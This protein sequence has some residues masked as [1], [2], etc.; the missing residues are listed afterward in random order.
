M[1]EKSLEQIAFEMGT[2]MLNDTVSFDKKLQDIIP[3]LSDYLKAAKCSIMLI[4]RDEMTVEV[5]AATN[6]AIMGFSRNLSDVTISTR[7]IIDDKPFHVGSGKRSFFDTLDSSRYKSDYSLSIPI[8]HLDKKLGVINF[9][10]FEATV[11]VDKETE[12]RAVELIKHFAAYLYAVMSREELQAKV[13]QLEGAVHELRNMNE[14]RANLTG[15]LMHGLKGPISTIVA[16]LDMMGYDPLTAEQAECLNLATEDVYRMQNMIMDML[17]VMKMEEGSIAVYRADADIRM[18]IER[19]ASSFSNL[20]ARR[21]IE[22][23]LDV[24]P[25]V[26]YIDESLIGRV[27]VNVLRNAISHTPDGGS[28]IIS[29]SYCDDPKETIVS[30]SDQGN[31]VPMDMRNKIFEKYCSGGDDIIALETGSGMG[32]TFCKLVVEAH[33]GHI[34]VEDAESGGAKFVFTLPETLTGK[35]LK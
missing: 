25:H 5:R 27:V 6:Q 9:T 32:L 31:G 3:I 19:E 22:L 16:N 12:Q 14:L 13:G 35:G 28:I 18:V 8:K 30:I 7:A 15:F 4:N 26:S 11:D 20:L 17:D 2:V 33:G 21:N 29:A 1:S 23:S 10:D 24:V 34:W